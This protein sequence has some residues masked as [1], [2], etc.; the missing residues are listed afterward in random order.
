MHNFPIQHME[1]ARAGSL[2]STDGEMKNRVSINFDIEVPALYKHPRH[3]IH[4]FS[5]SCLIQYN[6]YTY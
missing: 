2:K 1:K 3:Y 6:T 4:S 5:A